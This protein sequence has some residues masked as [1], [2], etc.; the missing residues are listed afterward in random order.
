M[1]A[2]LASLL[3]MQERLR[4]NSD[5]WAAHVD[6]NPDHPQALQYL[7]LAT[8]CA[9]LERDIDLLTK[10]ILEAKKPAGTC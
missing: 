3:K 9:N 8:D 4:T 10:L 2:K 1:P 7:R 5:A 6:K